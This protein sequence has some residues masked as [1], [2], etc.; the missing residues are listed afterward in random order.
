[1]TDVITDD[2][3]MNTKQWQHGYCCGAHD[4]A[5]L[6]VDKLTRRAEAPDPAPEGIA[7][8]DYFV[9]LLANWLRAPQ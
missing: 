7:L 3:L 1:M 2:T 9:V 8:R 6:V 5:Q 4:V